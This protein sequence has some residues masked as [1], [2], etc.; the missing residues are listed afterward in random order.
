MPDR[1]RELT[2]ERICREYQSLWAEMNLAQR[3]VALERITGAGGISRAEAVQRVSNPPCPRCGSTD[4]DRGD[5]ADACRA[6]GAVA[7]R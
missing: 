3:A 4:M 5:K 6:C 1:N 2:V 7:E